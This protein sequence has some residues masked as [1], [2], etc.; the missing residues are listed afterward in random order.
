MKNKNPLRFFSSLMSAGVPNLG[1]RDP[2]ERSGD[3]SEGSQTEKEN[4][5]RNYCNKKSAYFAQILCFS[6]W[7]L[8]FIACTFS[9]AL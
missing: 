8:C 4:K 3:K 1:V 6:S 7:K 2:P 9:S 5:N